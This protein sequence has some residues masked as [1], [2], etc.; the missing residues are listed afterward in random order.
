MAVPYLD[1][2]MQYAQSRQYRQLPALGQRLQGRIWQAQGQFEEA[3]P[4]FER[5]LAELEALD[6][7]VEYAHPSKPSVCSSSNASWPETRREVW[8]TLRGR[9]RFFRGW[10]LRDKTS[11]H[12]YS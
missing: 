1:Q 11:I 7:Q 5:S 12:S 3:L 2:A 6:D 8:S 9:R 10:V 4:C